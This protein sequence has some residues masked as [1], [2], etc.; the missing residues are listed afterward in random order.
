MVMKR[1][2]VWGLVITAAISLACDDRKSPWAPDVP[3]GVTRVELEGPADVAPGQTASLRAMAIFATGGRVDVTDTA[4]WGTSSASV[5]T[6]TAPGI[7]A[8]RERGEATISATYSGIRAVRPILVLE[9]GTYRIT[10]R[11]LWGTVPVAGARVVVSR[12]IG[13]GLATTSGSVG[14]FALYGV[15]GDIHLTISQDGYSETTRTLT[16]ASHATADVSL[17]PSEAPFDLSG[18]WILTVQAA[19]SCR[20]WPP[21]ANE[22]TYR[23]AVT[24]SGPSISVELRADRWIWG[25]SVV[26]IEGRV[27]SRTVTIEFPD[28]PIGGAWVQEQLPSGSVVEIGGL[29]QG[30]ASGDG[31]AGRLSG[32]IRWS[33][34]ALARAG[35]TS[36]D[37]AFRLARP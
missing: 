1:A 8:G 28:D 13:S 31:V 34:P 36:A 15:A 35:C 21:E 33:T 19:S 25:T 5:L 37:H 4:V 20:D 16:V 10:G 22:R 30:T 11:V 14:A 18:D 9:P 6:V 32:E 23:A 26:R 17:E 2:G 12:G 29:A 27:F 7:V 24:Q 3:A